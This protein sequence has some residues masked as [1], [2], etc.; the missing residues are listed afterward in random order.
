[1][2]KVYKLAANFNTVTIVDVEPKDLQRFLDWETEVEF[3]EDGTSE[4][5][6]S[7]D[8]LLERLLQHEYDLLAG[9]KVVQTAPNTTAKEVEEE[10]PSER[11]CDWARSLGMK[12]PEK[13]SKKEVWK[14]IQEHK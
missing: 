14:Y 13:K 9:I 10:K 2:K 12:N 5:D 3:H 11:Q 7:D 6:V 1:M 4:W 8:E